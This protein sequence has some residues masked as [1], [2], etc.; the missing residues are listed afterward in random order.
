MES[1]QRVPIGSQAGIAQ[2]A[3]RKL[4]EQ[5][6][7]GFRRAIK[8]GHVPGNDK[9]RGYSKKNCVLTI[10]KEEAQRRISFA[11]RRS[12]PG[13]T[14]DQ[15]SGKGYNTVITNDEWRIRLW[16]KTIPRS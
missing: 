1:A 9:P 14:L 11:A 4:S 15:S 10:N 16:R 13:D 2:K 6:K 7:S 12:H 8:N 3:L 5:L